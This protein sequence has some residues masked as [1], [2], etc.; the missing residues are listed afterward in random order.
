MPDPT[1]QEISENPREDDFVETS[2]DGSTNAP[3]TLSALQDEIDLFI[4]KGEIDT[5]EKQ[6]TLEN[7]FVSLYPRGTEI[8]VKWPRRIPDP[9]TIN[10]LRNTPLESTF[11]GSLAEYIALRKKVMTFRID[12]IDYY[13]ESPLKGRGQANAA[14]FLSSPNNPGKVLIKQDDPGT[15][16][17]EGCAVVYQPP[18]IT[19]AYP[20]IIQASS[21]I[22]SRGDQVFCASLQAAFTVSDTEEL[23]SLD[24][25]LL[26]MKRSPKIPINHEAL[27]DAIVSEDKKISAQIASFSEDAKKQLAYAIYMSQLNGDE[28]LHT[29]QF[30]VATRSTGTEGKKITKIQRIDMGAL[31]RFSQIR[32]EK[33]DF[34][35]F[36]TSEAYEKSSSQAGK[37]YL[38]YL[39]NNAEIRKELVELWLNT[40]TE[41]VIEAVK[42]RFADQL[43]E[44]AHDEN[45]KSAALTG[46]YKELVKGTSLELP[47]A[48]TTEALEKL[49]LTKLLDT[50]RARCDRMQAIAKEQSALLDT[51]S[52][53]T[54]VK[55]II[56]QSPLQEKIA[57][58]KSK[59]KP[60]VMTALDFSD[61]RQWL[62]LAKIAKTKKH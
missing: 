28:S 38:S 59:L 26:G 34:Y 47:K 46:F 30:M 33:E 2:N 25:F 21:K 45:I 53:T 12:E 24:V 49:V 15:C 36:N 13:F 50:T 1:T 18:N 31:G 32:R 5:D 44:L 60:D 11:E 42:K 51:I 62:F 35:L 54:N 57:R 56:P 3:K 58:I 19:F 6:K 9:K 8:K 55:V 16:L 29:A 39:A 37:N 22:V 52:E 43:L 61:D 40:N 41:D 48:I 17:A 20:P 14:A 4:Q 23:S 7:Y 10:L 27:F